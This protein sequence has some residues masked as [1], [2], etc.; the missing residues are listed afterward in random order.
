[1]FKSIKDINIICI[2]KIWI[3]SIDRQLIQ[4]PI[5]IFGVYIMLLAWKVTEHAWDMQ[6]LSN[7]V[8]Q[9]PPF[10]SVPQKYSGA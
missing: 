7:F 10:N 5:S 1:M 6:I 3:A 2:I 4:S 8:L 9:L